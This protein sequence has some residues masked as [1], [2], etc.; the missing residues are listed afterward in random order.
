[1]ADKSKK[2]PVSQK[3]VAIVLAS[4][5]ATMTLGSGA[6][7]V[8]E[9]GAI[10]TS[11]PGMATEPPKWAA[12]VPQATPLQPSRWTYIMI[13]ESADL[14]ASAASLA[15]GF[16]GGSPSPVRPKANFHF[17]IN[18]AS[19]GLDTVDGSLEVGTS[20]KNQDVGAFAGWPSSRSHSFSPYQDAVGICLVAD[21][22]RKPPSEAQ[23]GSLFSL[24]RQLQSRLNIPRERVLFQWD[25]QID[26]THATAQRQAFAQHFRTQLR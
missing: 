7:L 1:M 14:A 4:L 12:Y 11:V 15:G 2:K 19:S 16:S 24:V 17:V 25:S 26:S 5:V 13:Y 20:W 6:L 9:G 8:M 3:R 18:G 23:F 22:N 21:I 10:G